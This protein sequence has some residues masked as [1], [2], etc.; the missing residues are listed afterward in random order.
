MALRA[1]LSGFVPVI[2]V[3]PVLSLRAVEARR[4]ARVGCIFGEAG[5]RGSC[6]LYCG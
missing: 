4:V 5:V 6:G 3:G 1:G 2:G